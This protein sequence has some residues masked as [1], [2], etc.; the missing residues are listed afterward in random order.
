MGEMRAYPMRPAVEERV[1]E[2]LTTGK[3][4]PRIVRREALGHEWAPVER[5]TLDEPAIGGHSRV[6]VKY[7][8]TDGPGHGG[9]A[10]LRRE[11]VGLALTR[12]AEVSPQLLGYDASAGIV[13]TADV[14]DLPTLQDV[15]LA[16]DA[17]RAAAAMRAF[18]A[19][20]GRLHAT[21]WQAYGAYQRVAAEVGGNILY[22]SSFDGPAH[23][24]EVIS[25][26]AALGFPSAQSATR[27]VAVMAAA[28]NDPAPCGAL[29]HA[30][31]N[32]TNVLLDG[33]RAILVDFEGCR[34][35][36]AGADACFVHFPFPHHSR[37]WAVLPTGVVD[38][39]DSGAQILRRP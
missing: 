15:L 16:R 30:D 5:L 8:R 34:Y 29:V 37:P 14:G 27:D 11:T 25:A 33:D 32:P 13:V 1:L 2:L 6:V 24:N 38:Q 10:Y 19:T 22:G 4:R 3:R 9:P 17:D 36:P 20:M 31:L 26:C 35:G 18:G 28:L 39:A 12:G 7:R 21:T 23:F